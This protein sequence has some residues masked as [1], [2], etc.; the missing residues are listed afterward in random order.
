MA[1][2]EYVGWPP[3]VSFI[4]KPLIFNL[5]AQPNC[6]ITTLKQAFIVHSPIGD[7]LSLLLKLVAAGRGEFV[8]HH[9]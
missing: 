1:I 8:R 4:G 3:G 7:L 2:S 6:H 5:S 9:D